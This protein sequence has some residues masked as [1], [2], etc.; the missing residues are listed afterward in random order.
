MKNYKGF[1]L[2][3]L[4]VTI[5]IMGILA[6]VASPQLLFA[7]NSIENG[8]NQIA[9]IFKQSRARAIVAN[10]IYRIQ[11]TSTT[12]LS[13]QRGQARAC[14]ATTQLTSAALGTDI[15]LHVVSAANF[16][17]G[18][19]VQVGTSSSN[20]VIATD[21]NANTITLGQALG[22]YQPSNTSVNLLVNWVNDT[23]NFSTNDMTMPQGVY[24]TATNW[25]L[26]F[27]SR[28]IA[29]QYDTS[30]NVV[31]QSLTVNLANTNGKTGSVQVLQG[32]AVQ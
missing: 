13:I 29:T 6:A 9:S 11:P 3:E 19:Q 25:T 10:Y 7:N 2:P 31:L 22:S 21:L 4:L 1:T 24:M 8:T 17:V 26:C 28:G 5:S 27:N 16:T 23:T 32:G 14:T 12:R 15:L 20:N 30:G 18:D